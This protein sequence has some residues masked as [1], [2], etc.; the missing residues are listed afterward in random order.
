MIADVSSPVSA[1]LRKKTIA[2]SPD[3][4]AHD[5]D[6]RKR[7]PESEGGILLRG[8]RTSSY[9]RK[10]HPTAAVSKA[11]RNNRERIVPARDASLADSSKINPAHSN[12]NEANTPDKAAAAVCPQ[13][14]SA[15]ATIRTGR[16]NCSFRP[17]A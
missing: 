9:C 7:R 3:F 6:C 10:T 12:K 15:T 1:C 13:R 8:Y 14:K 4:K 2:L 11:M 5:E 17:D 16:G